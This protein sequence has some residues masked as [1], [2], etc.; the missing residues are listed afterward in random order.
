MSRVVYPEKK[1]KLMGS[2]DFREAIN[3]Y[4]KYNFIKCNHIKYNFIKYNQKI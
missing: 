4:I 2:A 1:C 3:N